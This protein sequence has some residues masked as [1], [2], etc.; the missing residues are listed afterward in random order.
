MLLNIMD[1]VRY[2]GTSTLSPRP[3]WPQA[4]IR[5]RATR[6]CLPLHHH[7]GTDPPTVPRRG[8]TSPI[9]MLSIVVWAPTPL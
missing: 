1:F 9:L 4:P 5:A 6:A 8:T 3:A 2:V 7:M